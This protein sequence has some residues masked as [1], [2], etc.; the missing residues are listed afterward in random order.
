HDRG[1]YRRL[2]DYVRDGELPAAARGLPPA[3]REVQDPAHL[4]AL[5]RRPDP[6]PCPAPRED[7][8][9]RDDVLVRGDALVHGRP[10]V[11]DRAALPRTQGRGH[12]PGAAEPARARS[13]LAAVRD[14][15]RS[16]DRALLA[17]RR[18]P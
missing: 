2:P 4:T 12:V 5:L 6:D 9:P 17:R 14:L 7:E 10:R 16:R 1:C 8:L 11:R 13:R 3:P 15:R 18:R